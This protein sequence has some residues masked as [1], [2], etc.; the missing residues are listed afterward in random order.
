MVQRYAESLRGGVTESDYG[1]WVAYDDYQK[2]EAELEALRQQV[3]A[4]S[5]D[6][7]IAWGG[8]DCP[9]PGGVMVRVRF[10]NGETGR[11]CAKYWDWRRK[12]DVYSIV[13]YRLYRPV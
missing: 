9:V 12:G 8:G 10:P 13:A 11:D 2:L 7:W 6:G 3:K 4:S 5:D 1:D